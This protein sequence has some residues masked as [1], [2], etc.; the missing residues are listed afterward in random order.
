MLSTLHMHETSAAH[1]LQTNYAEQNLRY[2]IFIHT[3]KN[4]WSYYTTT[5]PKSLLFIKRVL[6]FMLYR[7]VSLISGLIKN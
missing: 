1:A 6:L 5:Q 7:C 4:I 2:E 3:W